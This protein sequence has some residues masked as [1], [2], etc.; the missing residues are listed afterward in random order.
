MEESASQATAESSPALLGLKLVRSSRTRILKGGGQCD[1]GVLLIMYVL[2]VC[3]F[4]Y[5]EGGVTLRVVATT[6]S[7]G[8]K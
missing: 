5:F 8:G 6:C 1:A 4:C 3:M 7:G 2:C